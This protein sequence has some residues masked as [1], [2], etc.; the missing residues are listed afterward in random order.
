MTQSSHISLTE[1]FGQI[2]DPR[3]HQVDHLLIEI[4]IV[5]ICAAI[6]GA[7]NWVQVEQFGQAKERWLRKFLILPYG[8]PSHDTFSRVFAA[9]DAAQFQ[10]SFISWMR[11]VHGHT[12]QQVVP[13]DGKQLRRSHDKPLGK[14][15]IY[16]VSAWASANRFVLGQQKV[17]DKSNEITAMPLLLELLDLS[18]CIVTTDAM[19][20]QK[21]IARLIIEQEADYVLALKENHPGTYADVRSLFEYAQE[22]DFVDCDSHRTI[23]TGHGRVEIRQCWTVCAAD[24]MA[25]VR[26][27][28]KWPGLHTLVMVQTERYLPDQASTETRYYLSSLADTAEKHLQVVRTHWQI[29]NQLH[30]VLDMAFREDESR[31]RKGHG[32]ENFA[33]LRHIALSLLQQEQTA[34][35][36][37]QAKRLKAGWSEEYLL[38]IL[39][40]LT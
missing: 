39:S 2:S 28:A 34:K 16:M 9:L 25:Y 40:A 33:V 23:N 21:E 13:I 22:T 35:C 36:G 19:G 10:H 30:W 20:C 4:I 18:G 32:A 6:C 3:Q 31:I 29:E 7:D 1:H 24:Y 17:A 12:G 8:I 15:A 27:H 5:A 14:E 38:K 37:I 11:A 26:N